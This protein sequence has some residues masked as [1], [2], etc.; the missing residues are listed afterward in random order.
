MNRFEVR[1]RIRSGYLFGIPIRWAILLNF[2]LW[3]NAVFAADRPNILLIVADD[4]GA[5]D[6][7]C[8]GSDLHESPVLDDLAKNAIKFERAYAP[9]PVCTP[10]RAS[11]M[12]G[13]HPARL[14]IT[15]WSEGA[16]KPDRSRPLLPGDSLDHLPQ[17]YVTLA[18][19]LGSAGYRTAVVGK[20]HL[21]D[22]D[23]AAETQG[24]EVA[25]GGTRWG[26]PPTFFW[27]Y[28]NDT[29]FRDEFRYVPGLPFGRRGDYLTDALTSAAMRVIDDAGDDPFFLYLAHYAP[30]TPI[31]APEDLVR[32]YESKIQDHLRHRNP[33]YAAM[34]ENL[35]ANVGRVI[36]HLKRNGKYEN[37]LIVFTSDNGGFLGDPKGRNGVVTTNAPLRSGKGSA[38]EG[39]IRVPLIMKL[40]AGSVSEPDAIRARIIEER[41][42]LTDLHFVILDLAGLDPLPAGTIADGI[43]WA[44]NLTNTEKPWPNRPLYFHYPH[45]YETTTP[46]SAMIDG[47]HKLL[48]YTEDGHTEVYDLSSDPGEMKDISAADPHRTARVLA[49]LNHW[50][51]EVGAKEPTP[52]PQ[53]GKESGK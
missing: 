35:D 9:S 17:K 13:Q 38:Y 45:Y 36:D 48:H 23:M 42:L 11:L 21:G 31:E 40:P 6:L 3:A 30:H 20:W 27:P 46:V 28:K 47:D 4:L 50:K 37:T 41:V 33:T 52:N 1:T 14:G 34:I 18:E 49:M 44:G 39:G 2:G 25:I 22:G 24:F 29:R 8:Y 15:I 12:T 26:A 7:G 32:K 53:F 16:S 10:T 51:S 5:R 19:K 43:D